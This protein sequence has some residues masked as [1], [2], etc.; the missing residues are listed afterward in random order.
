[1]IERNWRTS[2]PVIA[3][4]GL[5][6]SISPAAAAPLQAEECERVRVEQSALTA[7]GVREDIERGAAWGR[8]NLSRDRLKDI[9]RWI[10]FEEQ[11]LFRCPR[12]KPPETEKAG[13]G[14]GK[15]Q[16]PVIDA[17]IPLPV[18][19]PARLSGGQ[20][21]EQPVPGPPDQPAQKPA[22]RPA[23]KAV[24]KPAQKPVDKKPKVNDAYV[25]PAPYSGGIDYQHATPGGASSEGSGWSLSP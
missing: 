4:I 18:P 3:L 20:A 14:A 22:E 11:L 16:T 8:D 24:Q 2:V 23:E 13:P 19:K 17:T 12:P 15:G 6:V 5:S 1:M 7:A 21:A 10:E 9:A 25:P